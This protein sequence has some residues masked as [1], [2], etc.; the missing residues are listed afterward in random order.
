MAGPEELDLA[1]APAKKGGAKKI[2]LVA[3]LVLGGLLAVAGVM[4]GTLWALGA[5]PSGDGHSAEEVVEVDGEGADEGKGKGKEERPAVY[6]EIA[7]P[8]V[9][10][11]NGQGKARFLQVSVEVMGRDEAKLEDALHHTPA[12]RNKM[13]LLF[14]S[15]TYDALSTSSGKETLRENAL[16][17]VQAVLEKEMGSSPVEDLFFTSLV[18]Q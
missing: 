14:S 7:P 8:F 12:I 6:M 4:V 5:V 3:A 2:I 13:L 10:N 1:A 18:M 9:V 17:E 16:L 11:F 15:Q